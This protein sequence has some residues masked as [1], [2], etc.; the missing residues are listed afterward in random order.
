V[1]APA[2]RAWRAERPGQRLVV[3]FDRHSHEPRAQS[4]TAFVRSQFEK[5]V[6]TFYPLM[7]LEEAN[8]LDDVEYQ[9]VRWVPAVSGLGDPVGKRL[10]FGRSWVPGADDSSRVAKRDWATSKTLTSSKTTR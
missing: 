7:Y 1:A 10:E 2:A 8:N 5:L 4:D 9:Q 3:A 6:L